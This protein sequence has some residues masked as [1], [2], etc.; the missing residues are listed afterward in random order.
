MSRKVGTNPRKFENGHLT[1]L[2]TAE[3]Q[4]AKTVA[5]L[6][7]FA[8]TVQQYIMLGSGESKI[9]V[10]ANPTKTNDI[11]LKRRGERGDC[12]CR[13]EPNPYQR[14]TSSNV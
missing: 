4:A 8:R 9:S 3:A 6:A 11:R 12:R 2:G 13:G 7:K 5:A 10:G 14:K 1:H